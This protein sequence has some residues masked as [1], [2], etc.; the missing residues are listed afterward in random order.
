M[1]ELLEKTNIYSSRR[2]NT[3]YMKE[4]KQTAVDIILEQPHYYGLLGRV[5]REVEEK[6]VELKR[7]LSTTEEV[8][9]VND[10]IMKE[11]K[12]Q[13]LRKLKSQKR[14]KSQEWVNY[15]QI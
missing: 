3:S 14:K 7:R 5:L 10:E 8:D 2:E 11:Q 1:L 12:R 13:Q 9:L 4:K 15:E 6:A